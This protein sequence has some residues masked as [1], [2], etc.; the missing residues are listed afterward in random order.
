MI[1]LLT[2]EEADLL[3]PKAKIIRNDI[4]NGYVKGFRCN[5]VKGKDNTL[6][7]FCYKGGRKD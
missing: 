1:P 6:E 4:K 5:T 2:E 3:R 7:V